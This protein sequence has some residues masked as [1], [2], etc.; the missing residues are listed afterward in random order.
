M[1]DTNTNEN[2]ANATILISDK[3]R[4]IEYHI[5]NYLKYY[6]KYRAI[7]HNGKRKKKSLRNHN[8]NKHA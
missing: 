8:S 7:F 5:D 2:K 1:Q 6:Q 3:F 4:D